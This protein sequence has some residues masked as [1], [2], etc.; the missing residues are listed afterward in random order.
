MPWA[1]ACACAC[2]MALLIAADPTVF[3]LSCTLNDMFGTGI[4]PVGV[5]G[6]DTPDAP[7]DTPI[8]VISAPL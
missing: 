1:C 7:C 2:W 8:M 3:T 6:T 5:S 4:D